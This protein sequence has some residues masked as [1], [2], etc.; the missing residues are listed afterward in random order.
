MLFRSLKKNIPEQRISNDYWMS[1]IY[2]YFVNGID[3]DKLFEE[4]V[5]NLKPEDIKNAAKLFVESGN[6]IEVV[7][8]PEKAAEAE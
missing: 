4:A 6:F 8:E 5:N 3:E 7:M 2:K 1:S